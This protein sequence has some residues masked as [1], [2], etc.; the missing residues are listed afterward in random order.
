M[1]LTSVILNTFNA[2][3]Q[4]NMCRY[5]TQTFDQRSEHM[6]GSTATRE[7]GTGEEHNEIKSRS[8]CS[9]TVCHL[10][11]LLLMP[12]LW[13]LVVYYSALNNTIDRISVHIV[14]A[15]WNVVCAQPKFRALAIRRGSTW[16]LLNLS[17][18]WRDSRADHS[19]CYIKIKH[20]TPL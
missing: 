3:P 10:Y 5:I 18:I 19:S 20:Q 16:I 12:L 8:V 7:C 4:W 9:T 13:M 17:F 2:L 6:R 11:L 15:M 14:C 1:L